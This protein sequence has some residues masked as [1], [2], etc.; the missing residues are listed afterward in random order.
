MARSLYR[1][2]LAAFPFSI[3]VNIAAADSVSARDTS[4]N[5]DRNTQIADEQFQLAAGNKAHASSVPY[6][7]VWAPGGRPLTRFTNTPVSVG[8]EQIREAV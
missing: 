6:G 2:I 5:F 3:C 8:G 4:C 1:L 7:K